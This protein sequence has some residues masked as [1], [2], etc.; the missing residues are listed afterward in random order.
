MYID[1][2][3]VETLLSEQV[4]DKLLSYGNVVSGSI[5][6]AK[7]QHMIDAAESEINSFLIP[8]GYTVPL[9]TVPA[10]V[11]M[12]AYYITINHLYNSANQPLPE[13]QQ[14]ELSKQ[15][16]FLNAVKSQEIILEGNLQNNT[17]G[18]AGSTFY[19]NTSNNESGR[20]LDIKNLRGTFT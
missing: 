19:Y 15:Y 11:K 18:T 3:Y 12:A 6:D 13:V 17:T 5:K 20:I 2:T 9:P 16:S 8:A 1:Q 10:S 7:L 14:N 4:V